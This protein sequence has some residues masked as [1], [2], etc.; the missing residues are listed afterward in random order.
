[1]QRFLRILV[2]LSLL[3]PALSLSVAAVQAEGSSTSSQAQTATTTT[4]TE[5]ADDTPQGTLADRM[6]QNKSAFKEN[7]TKAAQTALKTRCKAAQGLLSSLS[8]R[9][10]GIQTSRNEVYTNIVDHL[11]SLQTKLQNKDVDT[12]ELQ[13]EI[14]TLQTKITTYKTD[15]TAY[16]Q[17]VADLAAM[18]CASD[19]AA[20][21]STLD[22]ARA[23]REKVAK[24]SADIKAYVTDTIKPTLVKIRTTLEAN[25]QK[26][27][28]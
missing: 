5:T 25:E 26:A 10:K 7:L 27:Q 13:A 28:N 19:P 24:D 11:T 14:A 9:I 1:M 15:L 8:G 20:F 17:A 3:T 18:D 22:A 12:T 2:V 21:K 16:K 6:N 4:D 23:A